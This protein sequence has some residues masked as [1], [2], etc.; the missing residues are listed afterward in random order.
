MATRAVLAWT[1]WA[2][3]TLG[4]IG[5]SFFLGVPAGPGLFFAGLLS[6]SLGG[7]RAIMVFRHRRGRVPQVNRWRRLIVGVYVA[8][9]LGVGIPSFLTDTLNLVNGTFLGALLLFAPWMFAALG[10]S[11]PNRPGW[12]RSEALTAIEV[13]RNRP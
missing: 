12:V 3:L 2:L 9:F 7:A 1:A 13:E 4:A 6:I 10:A 5:V 11:D 8:A